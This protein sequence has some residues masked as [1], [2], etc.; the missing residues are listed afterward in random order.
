MKDSTKSCLGFSALILALGLASVSLLVGGV[1]ELVTQFGGNSLG[2]NFRTGL[3][4]AFVVFGLLFLTALYFFISVR[5]WSWIPA[6]L[7]GVYAILPDIVL[8]P[9]DDVAALTLGVV[10]SAVLNYFMNR[11]GQP[12]PA[13]RPELPPEA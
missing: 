8:G 3:I 7:G 5:D 9:Q 2:I 6:I 13:D 12:K 11:R 10:A 1:G 4:G